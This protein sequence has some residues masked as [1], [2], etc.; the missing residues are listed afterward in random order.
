V[1]IKRREARI[2]AMQALFQLDAQGGDFLDQLPG[3]LSES[4]D[5]REVI[6]YA[7]LLVRGAWS[8]RGRIDELIGQMSENWSVDRMPGV[9][10]SILRLAAFELMQADEPPPAVV[11]N[12]AIELGKLFGGAETPHFINGV[13]DAVRGRLAEASGSSSA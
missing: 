6:E 11:I 12:E 3:F 2:L 8:R 7:D 1:R 4:T 5:D 9:D 13:L 10:R